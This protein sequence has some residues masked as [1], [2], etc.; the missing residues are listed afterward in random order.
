M[1]VV[2]CWGRENKLEIEIKIN[3]ERDKGSWGGSENG[4]GVILPAMAHLWWPADSAT[5]AMRVVGFLGTLT[6]K[7][8]KREKNEK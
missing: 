8:K 7:E 4:V 2:V 3:N 1:G 6:L 5:M